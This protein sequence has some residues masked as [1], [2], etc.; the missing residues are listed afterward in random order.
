M[1]AILAPTVSPGVRDLD[2]RLVAWFDLDAV[3]SAERAVRAGIAQRIPVVGVF[4]VSVD[5]SP[6]PIGEL[7][8]LHRVGRLARALTDASGVVPIIGIVA[9]QVSGPESLLL[10]LVDLVITTEGGLACVSGP[11]EVA[12][13]TGRDVTAAA[14]GGSDVLGRRSG[15]AWL[16]ATD[17]AHAERLAGQVLAHLPDHAGDS[18]PVFAT[19]DPSARLSDR[20]GVVV[21]ADPKASYDVRDVI[22]DIVDEGDFLELRAGWA[23]TLVTGLASVGGHVVGVVANQPACLAGTLDIAGAQKGARFVRWCDAFGLPLLTLVDTPGYLPGK[24]VEWQ[25]MIRKGAQLA[26]AYAAATV[27]RICVVLRKAYGGAYIVMDSKGMGNDLCLAWPSAEIAV[28]GAAGAVAILHR[29]QLAD[30]PEPERAALRAELEASYAARHLRP[31]PAL[32][33][34]Y[35]DEVIDPAD[36]R[37]RVA[38]AL[39]SLTRKTA[40][41]PSRRHDNIPL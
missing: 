25:G 41:I 13:W 36:T 33:R 19:V 35:V 24:D 1:T 14:L 28:M 37:P 5:G 16:D 9:G 8:D 15:V 18:R 10:G 4:G 34:G 32:E 22:V 20:A 27:P 29:R 3:G 26:H 17:R 11:D 23:Q 30:T 40:T 2:G 21:P 39:A 6:S 7:A 38:R 12:A 31:E